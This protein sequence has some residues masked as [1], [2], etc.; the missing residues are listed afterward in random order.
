MLDIQHLTRRYQNK[1]AVSDLSLTFEKGKTYALL[2]PNGSGKTTLM[3]MIAGL[4][5]QTSGE[6]TLDGIPVG[7]E[8]KK[9]IAYMP[10][11]SYFYSYMSIADAGKYYA[12]FFEDFDE[13]LQIKSQAPNGTCCKEIWQKVGR[14]KCSTNKPPQSAGL[15]REK[16]K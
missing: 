3:K 16:R 12:D 10:T 6:I 11:E 8:T 14:K 5:K 15:K 4:T 13:S 7:P 2:G 9:H 1:L